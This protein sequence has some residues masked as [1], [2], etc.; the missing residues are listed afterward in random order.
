MADVP[1]AAVSARGLAF[2]WYHFDDL[3]KGLL[4]ALLQLRQQVFVVE[5]HCA[6]AD[7]DGQDTQ[8]WHLLVREGAELIA[9]ARVQM[10]APNRVRIGRV[11]VAPPWRT[12]GLGHAL[13]QEV[14]RYAQACW[15]DATLALAAQAHLESFYR[16]HGFGAVSPPYDEDGI[17]HIDMMRLPAGAGHARR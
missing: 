7:A 12:Q 15:P 1:I 11:L 9:C 3:E 14:L 10:Q 6:Y 16:A 5:Q 4:Y 2:D 8:A 17:M 13:M